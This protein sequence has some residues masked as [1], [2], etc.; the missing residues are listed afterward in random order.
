MK[1]RGD[2]TADKV[3]RTQVS[4]CGLRVCVCVCV[5]GPH[6]PS[7]LRRQRKPHP[8]LTPTAQTVPRVVPQANPR[9]IRHM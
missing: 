6:S 5:H 2:L 1:D 3:G 7:G 8:A 9:L 4:C